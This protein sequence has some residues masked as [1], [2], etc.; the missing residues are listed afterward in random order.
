[1]KDKVMKESMST[2]VIRDILSVEDEASSI[3][4]A[5]KKKAEEILSQADIDAV[6]LVHSAVEA[7]HARAQAHLAEIQALLKAETKKSQQEIDSLGAQDIPL[8]SEQI[9]SIASDIVSLV[10]SSPLFPQRI[11]ETL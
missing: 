4:L 6:A 10:C 2:R 11:M 5:A 1:M 9:D 8:T 7:E 3:E